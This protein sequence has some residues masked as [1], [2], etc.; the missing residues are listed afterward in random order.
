MSR[1]SS[2]K[3]HHH[4]SPPAFANFFSDDMSDDH[5]TFY[6]SMYDDM[7]D[8]AFAGT[9]VPRRWLRK[10]LLLSMV[11]TLGMAVLSV[12]S[13]R[14]FSRV[15][16]ITLAQNHEE[17]TSKILAHLSAQLVAAGIINS[18]SP[19]P[20]PRPPQSCKYNPA[21][22]HLSLPWLYGSVVSLTCALG[23]LQI[24]ARVRKGFQEHSR[25][26]YAVRIGLGSAGVLFCVG[27]LKCLS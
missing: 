3:S 11:M 16:L 2:Y 10:L 24:I 6:P 19:I 15:G 23:T 25:E 20:L 18:T 17:I 13:M 9:A 26:E 14:I 1:R 27:V 7:R 4:D 21:M 5:S 12:H 8:Q 22:C